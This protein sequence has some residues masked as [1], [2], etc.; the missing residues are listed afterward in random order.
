MVGHKIIARYILTRT[1]STT[2]KVACVSDCHPSH[3]L[4]S[5]HADSPARPKEKNIA[6]I[7]AAAAS[8]F[9]ADGEKF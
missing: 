7:I 5:A 1:Y 9:G 6:K 4:L 2:G 3:A 8:R